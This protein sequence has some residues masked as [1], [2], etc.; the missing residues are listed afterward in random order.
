VSLKGQTGGEGRAGQGV[1]LAALC[2]L[3][4]G[5]GAEQ[6]RG[7]GREAA[8]GRV[9]G[10]GGASGGTQRGGVPPSPPRQPAAPTGVTPPAASWP[11]PPSCT[12]QPLN[13]RPVC[14]I[15]TSPDMNHTPILLPPPP[16]ATQVHLHAAAPPDG[17]HL[18]AS[19]T[20][21]TLGLLLS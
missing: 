17:H 8:Q 9:R 7:D 4:S 19:G 16:P 2:S 18:P 12:W 1:V 5:S 3:K 11:P 21:S 15:K 13:P 6:V 20:H 10:R 14:Y